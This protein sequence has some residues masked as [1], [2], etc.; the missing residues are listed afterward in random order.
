VANGRKDEVYG[1]RCRRVCV[2]R[3]ER[4]RYHQGG[5]CAPEAAQQKTAY[6]G[7]EARLRMDYRRTY[8]VTS[9]SD[10]GN[11]SRK[12]AA[13]DKNLPAEL[14][15]FRKAACAASAASGPFWT[16]KLNFGTCIA[17]AREKQVMQSYYT[18]F[19][20]YYRFRPIILY[21]LPNKS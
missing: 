14:N 21:K 2:S 11:Y 16:K 15:S 4:S 5:E 20:A 1:S 12:A 19:G 3:K 18:R 9:Q 10:A 8:D 17:C 7:A 13:D 6:G